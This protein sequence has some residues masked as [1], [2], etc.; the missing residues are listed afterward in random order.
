MSRILLLSALRWWRQRI[1]LLPRGIICYSSQNLKYRF[2]KHPLSFFFFLLH[3]VACC[4]FLNFRH[5]KGLGIIQTEKKVRERLMRLRLLLHANVYWHFGLF[6]FFFF[7]STVSEQ[8]ERA[9]TLGLAG[10]L[11]EGVYN[12]GELVRD[13]TFF[14]LLSTRSWFYPFNSVLH[15]SYSSCTLFW[16]PWEALIGSGWLIRFMP[17]T[18]VM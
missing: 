5:G 10:L 13:A 11:G 4:R 18:V 1:V 2:E 8:Q 6:G 3:S 16:S 12:F 9:F 17:S 7:I 14:Q 15:M